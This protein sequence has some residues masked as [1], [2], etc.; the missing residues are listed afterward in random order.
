MCLKIWKNALNTL[1]DIYY[2]A[3]LGSEGY[4]MYI[5]GQK[6][7]TSKNSKVDKVVHFP[8]GFEQLYNFN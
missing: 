8:E 4:N 2:N 7:N 1:L 5:R 6:L 3:P